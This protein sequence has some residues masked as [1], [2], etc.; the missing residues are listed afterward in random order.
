[1]KHIL[2]LSILLL[3]GLFLCGCSEQNQG[4]DLN[5]LENIESTLPV[6]SIETINR[7]TNVMDFVTAPVAGHVSSQIATWTPDYEMPPEP[8]YEKCTISLTNIDGTK[9]LDAVTGEVKVRGNW[10]TTY[11]KKPLRIKFDKPQDMLRMNDGTKFKNWLLLAEYKDASLLRNKTALS[12]A[13]DLLQRDGH[14]ITDAEFVEVYINGNYWGVYLLAEQQQVH[15]ERVDISSV[16]T[17]YTGTDIGYFLELDGYYYNEDALHQFRMEYADNAPLIPYDGN[18]GSGRSIEPLSTID[19]G[20]SI[21]S[22]INSPAQRDFIASFVNNVYEIMYAAAYR[23]EAYRFNADYS[24]IEK[25]AD[26]TP[27]EAV[28]QVVDIQSLV[29]TYIL[30]EV[31]CDADIY[32]SSFYMTVDFGEGGNKKLTFEAPWDFDSALGLKSR[33]PDGTGFY[34]ANIVPDVNGGPAYGGFET[35]NPWLAVLANA[36]WYQEL[37]KDTWTAAYDDD[38]FDRALQMITTDAENCKTAFANNYKKWDNIIN[39]GSFASE[40]SAKAAACKNETE[41]IA[42]LYEWLEAR[43]NF[44]NEQWHR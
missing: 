2:K 39:N 30:N 17:D 10:T 15:E 37:V 6:I 12:I 24:A 36:D 3:L 21:A 8:Y 40:L 16:P 11:D 44:L 29:D 25:T 7:D 9:M 28:E 35:I 14:Y 4:T 41:A 42:Y 23:N 43:V 19:G 31:V 5:S 1:M 20:M 38:V 18:D 22:D 32:Y 27:Q 34:A 13:R 26:L 33:C